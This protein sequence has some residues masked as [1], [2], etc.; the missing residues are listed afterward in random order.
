M[1]KATI[2]V[3]PGKLLCRSFVPRVLRIGKKFHHLPGLSCILHDGSRWRM[4]WSGNSGADVY[5]WRRYFRLAEFT[6]LAIR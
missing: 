4:A 1:V 6:W 5:L 3:E 2:L